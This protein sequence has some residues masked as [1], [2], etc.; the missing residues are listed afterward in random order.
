[1]SLLPP[2]LGSQ[3][4]HVFPTRLTHVFKHF[5]LFF[6]VGGGKGKGAQGFH[7]CDVKFI[8]TLKLS[9][10][11]PCKKLFYIFFFLKK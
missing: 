6:L 1:M 2:G 5:C 3:E 4:S 8:F 7:N 11:P 10:L 9:F